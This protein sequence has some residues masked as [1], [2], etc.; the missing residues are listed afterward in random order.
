MRRA[1]N[2]VHLHRR[3]GGLTVVAVLIAT[4][5]LLS[6]EVGRSEPRAAHPVRTAAEVARAAKPA[7]PSPVRPVAPLSVSPP[8]HTTPGWTT[9]AKVHGQ[10]A[11]WLAQRSGVTLMRFDQGL[12]HLTLHAGSSDGGVM[13][14]P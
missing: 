12:V 1:N 3:L 7:S 11:A 13:L 9:V 14:S 6:T 2:G 10:P 8:A 4:G 5:A